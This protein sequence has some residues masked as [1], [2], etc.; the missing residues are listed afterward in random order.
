LVYPLRLGSDLD[1]YF[2]A[3][4]IA[5]VAVRNQLSIP[6][7]DAAYM[8]VYGHEDLCKVWPWR[9]IKI[10]E[11]SQFSVNSGTDKGTNLESLRYEE[12]T[13][14]YIIFTYQSTSC[15]LVDHESEVVEYPAL[16]SKSRSVDGVM[17]L[18]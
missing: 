4:R 18:V 5:R 2:N 3:I 12:V 16:A 17:G 1:Y 10:M 15:E 8:S 6:Y 13:R 7:D 11:H 14:H 9:W